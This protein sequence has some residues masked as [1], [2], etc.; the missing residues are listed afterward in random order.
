MHLIRKNVFNKYFLLQV[1]KLAIAEQLARQMDPNAQEHLYGVDELAIL[2]RRHFEAALR[3]PTGS[4]ADRQRYEL[5]A[6]R[7]QSNGML[8]FNPPSASSTTTTFTILDDDD[9]LYNC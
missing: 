2:E 9:D 3:R 1:V 7:M 6:Q 5:F 8:E 4:S